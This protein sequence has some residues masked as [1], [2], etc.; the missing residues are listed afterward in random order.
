MNLPSVS[1]TALALSLAVTTE[2]LI[3]LAKSGKDSCAY[4]I[5]INKNMANNVGN[6]KFINLRNLKQG[7]LQEAIPLGVIPD[8]PCI[9]PN[10]L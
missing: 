8:Y 2:S 7:F 10:F 4:T 5:A 6:K 9:M 1:I 3:L